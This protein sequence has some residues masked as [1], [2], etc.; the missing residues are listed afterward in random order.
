MATILVI[1]G[2]RTLSDKLRSMLSSQ[3]H[4]VLLAKDGIEGLE[5]FRQKR[6]RFTL[7]DFQ[8]PGMDGIAVLEQI[9]TTDPTAAVIMLDGGVP[10]D[11]KIQAWRLGALDFMKKD[12]P[13]KVLIN[14]V[15]RAMLRSPRVPEVSRES[16]LILVVDDEPPLCKM[17]SDHFTKL[18][19]RVLTANNGQQ[20]LALI[21]RVTPQLIIIDIYMPIVDGLALARELRARKYA[22]NM[23][24]LTGSLDEGKLQEMLDLGAMDVIGKPIPMERLELAV[25]LGCILAADDGSPSRPVAAPSR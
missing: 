11:L 9:R 2:E 3:G 12:L 17:V 13:L 19:Y 24:A 6:P 25:H 21:E 23:L 18:G 20:A 7:L 4:E 8:P 1:E 10:G 15:G 5:L 14:V 22:G 16:A